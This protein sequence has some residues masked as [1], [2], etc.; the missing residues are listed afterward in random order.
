MKRISALTLLFTGSLFAQDFRATLTGIVTDPS[1]AA[2]PGATVKTT[3]VG[4]NAIKETKTT[5]DGVYTIPYLDP[6]VYN[7]EASSAGFQTLK[8]EKIVLEVAQKALAK[9]GE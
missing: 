9:Q 8:R 4:T 2:V 7:I 3:N 1:G 6:G 5:G